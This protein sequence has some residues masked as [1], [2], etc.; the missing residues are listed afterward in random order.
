MF[1]PSEAVYAELHASFPELVDGA[2]KARVWIVSPTTLMATL[3]TIR[4]VLKDVRMREQA[5]VIQ[6]K[7]GELAQD[8]NR[9]G[10]R[11]DKLKNHFG[12]AVEDIRQIEISTDKIRQK[13]AVIGDVELEASGGNVLEISDSAGA[14]RLN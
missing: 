13:S 2:G 1:L 6:K 7:V 3:T 8:V 9:L 12:Q 14:P 5:H 10:D 11:V 4:A